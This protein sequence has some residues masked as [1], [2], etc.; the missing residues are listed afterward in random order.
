MEHPDILKKVKFDTLTQALEYAAKTSKGVNFYDENGDL[1]SWHSYADLQQEAVLV[2]SKLASLGLPRHSFIGVIAQVS[3]EFPLMFYA[4]QY[5]GFIPCPLPSDYISG[6][7]EGYVRSLLAI[8]NKTKI[9]VFIVPENYRFLVQKVLHETEKSRQ[10]TFFNFDEIRRLTSENNITPF[11]ADDPAYLQFSSGSTANP[12]GIWVTQKSAT[13]SVANLLKYG[14]EARS[15]NRT[16]SWIPFY[17][18]A[19][20]SGV[21]LATVAGI[22]TCDYISPATFI[23]NPSVWIKLLSQNPEPKTTFAPSFAWEIASKI[24]NP[25]DYDLSSLRIA[26]IAG[27]TIRLNALEAFDRT[28]RNSGFK[29][30]NFLSCYGLSE[31][32]SGIVYDHPEKGL[33]IYQDQNGKEH[34]SVGSAFPSVDLIVVDDKG[35]ALPEKETGYIWIRAPELH[36]EYFEDK[37]AMQALSRRDGYY[38]TGD[39]GFIAD[40][41][42]F[43]SGRSKDMI[44]FKG[45]NIWPQDIETIAES[46]LASSK[47]A[48][49]FSVETDMA[50]KII[51][52]AESDEQ[53]PEKRKELFSEIRSAILLNLGISAEIV[54]VPKKTLPYTESNKPARAQA[55]EL[56][57]RE[58]MKLSHKEGKV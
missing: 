12:K 24:P 9:S 52:L 38:D 48:I 4:C 30:E 44:L 20:L 28:F 41:R 37:E 13:A 11:H 3:Y 34:V 50:E 16:V 1:I 54:F 45:R 27:D 6:G 39:M 26:G 40:G 17:H 36:C 43:I 49:A 55:R 46:C 2:A 7:E 14:L 35:E 32:V 56:Y 53:I 51:V 15:T 19:G 47:S 5:A 21:L 29:R 18:T 58:Y 22:S 8:A 10:S 25:G 31:F 57:I 33:H 42:L 23:R